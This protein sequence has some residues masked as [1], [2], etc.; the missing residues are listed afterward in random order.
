MTLEGHVDFSR[1]DVNLIVG[2][3][4]TRI[5]GPRQIQDALARLVARLC[6]SGLEPA[7]LERDTAAEERVAQPVALERRI[8]RLRSHFTPHIVRLVVLLKH[9]V[10]SKTDRSEPATWLA[11]RIECTGANDSRWSILHRRHI[12]L[13]AVLAI[14]LRH[15]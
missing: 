1:F 4:R 5:A 11:G 12:E 13:D 9:H 3:E 10:V 8:E 6:G 2:D 14:D 15:G 7:L